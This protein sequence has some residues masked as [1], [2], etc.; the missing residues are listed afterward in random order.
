MEFHHIGIA[1]DNIE[2]TLLKLKK[3]F[4]IIEVSKVCYDAN[5]DANLCMVT[6][7]NGIKIELINGIDGEISIYSQGDFV[8]LCAGPHLAKVSQIQH[9][10][11]LSLAGAY[12][13][14]NVKNKQLTR[15]YGTSFLVKKNLKNI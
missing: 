9:F 8:D 7:N 15:I 1:T 14:G 11:L 3:Y 6:L 2:K 12:W 5:Q 10:K 13:R 4:K